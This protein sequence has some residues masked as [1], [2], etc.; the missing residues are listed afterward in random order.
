M[1]SVSRARLVPQSDWPMPGAV[2]QPPSAFCVANRYEPTLL[3]IF[4]CLHKAIVHQAVASTE[5]RCPGWY[6][7]QPPWSCLMMYSRAFWCLSCSEVACML[8]RPDKEENC[9]WPSL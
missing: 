1:P 4:T 8:G 3:P 7:H 2:D 5:G 9:D 6:G